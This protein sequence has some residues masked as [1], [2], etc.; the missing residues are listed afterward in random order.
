MNDIK[1]TNTNIQQIIFPVGYE[2][3]KIEKKP[4]KK[5]GIGTRR[6]KAL[7]ELKTTLQQYDTVIN[8]AKE[9]NISLPKEIIHLILFRL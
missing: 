8:E 1:N 7:S 3:R 9:N 5:K 2:L 4:K 6:K